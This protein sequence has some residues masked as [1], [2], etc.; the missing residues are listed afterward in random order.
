MRVSRQSTFSNCHFSASR[1]PGVNATVT[2]N[3]C[4]DR[5]GLLSIYC[6]VYYRLQ[7]LIMEILY[8]AKNGVHAFGYYS[9][10]SE[11]IWIKSG[12]P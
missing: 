1:L 6:G 5:V 8:G 12:A 2:T 4:C 9:A 3:V 11:S 10:E 7:E